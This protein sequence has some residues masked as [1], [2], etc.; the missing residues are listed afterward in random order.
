MRAILVLLAVLL[1]GCQET[2]FFV[3]EDPPYTTQPG[4]IEGR[5]CD[6]SGRT[7]LGDAQVYTYLRSDDGHIYCV[8]A[9]KGTQIP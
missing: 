5:V 7:W 3:K 2:T 1:V 8:D 4:S 6:P 9:E